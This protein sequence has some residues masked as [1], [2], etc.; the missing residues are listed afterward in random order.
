MEGTR[1]KDYCQ[2]THHTIL[3]ME[4]CR[5]V[6]INKN[7]EIKM[8]KGKQFLKFGNS[9]TSKRYIKIIAEPFRGKKKILRALQEELG[10]ISLAG[11]SLKS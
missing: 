9:N 11:H 3:T 8:E 2:C 4:P 6:C 7:K 1:R 5:L 10:Y